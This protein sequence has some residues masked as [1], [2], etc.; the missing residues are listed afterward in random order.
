MPRV[1]T[2]DTGLRAPTIH[3]VAAPVDTFVRPAADTQ[4]EQLTASLAKFSPALMQFGGV[5]GQHVDD[6]ALTSGKLAAEKIKN[7][8]MTYAEATRKGKIPASHNPY[9]MAGL[10]EQLG[11]NMADKL[12]GDMKEAVGKNED[13]ADSTDVGAFDKFAGEFRTQWM[14]D[15]IGEGD[16]D[17]DFSTGFQFR[18]DAY[19]NQAR[20]GFASGIEGKVQTQSSE[21]TFA[22]VY[23]HVTANATHMTPK[24]IAE[25]INNLSDDLITKHGRNST[26]VLQ[27]TAKAVAAAALNS[28]DHGFTIAEVLK[29][30]KGKGGPSSAAM[31]AYDQIREKLADRKWQNNQRAEA[32]VVKERADRTRD[33][34]SEA[35]KEIIKNPHTDLSAFAAKLPDVPEAVESLTG[36]QNNV[37]HWSTMKTDEKVKEDLFARIYTVSGGQ[38]FVSALS[39]V[40]MMRSGKLTA[41]DADWLVN[42]VQE[43]DK[44]LVEGEPLKKAAAD[45]DFTG[46]LQNLDARF[47]KP[48]ATMISGE[49]GHRIANAEAMLRHGWYDLWSSG[50]A[51]KMTRQERVEWLSAEATRL[52]DRDTGHIKMTPAKE[53]LFKPLTKPEEMPKEPLLTRDDITAYNKGTVTAKLHE[54]IATYGLTAVTLPMFIAAQLDAVYGSATRQLVPGNIDLTNRPRVSNPDGSISTVRSISIN[55]NG[56]EIL[57]PTVSDDGHVLSNDDAV[58]LYHKTGKHLGIF[59]NAASATAYAKELHRQQE[60]QLTTPKPKP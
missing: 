5:I 52:H 17:Q 31:L 38:G 51:A 58:A 37:Q 33:V 23:K 22:E 47:D 56:R 43:R 45:P 55:E 16:Q 41:A 10:R 29:E 59:P 24:Q 48:L 46:E 9:F 2:G 4:L 44:A 11:R 7:D 60:R 35:V 25:D 12:D 49:R 21:A 15:N 8:G 27:A 1:Q 53:P 14:K 34:L 19:I 26:Q 54:Q 32:T 40:Q 28:D 39:V 36:I 18:A 42:R 30:L 3:P 13:L 6:N 57:I 20:N 50:A